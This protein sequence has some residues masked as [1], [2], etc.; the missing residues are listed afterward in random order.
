MKLASLT[1]DMGK[2]LGGTKSSDG[3]YIDHGDGTITDTRTNLMWAKKDS[4]SDTGSCMN[5]NDSRSYVSSLSTG[6]YSGWWMP[7]VQELKGIYDSSKRLMAFDNDSSTPLHLDSIFADGAAYWYW[8][9]ETV[10]S[11][12]ARIVSFG[13][14][15]VF[16]D[17]RDSCGNRGVRAVRR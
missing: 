17:G 15:N 10:G 9:S 12:R 7:T 13:S 4:Y 2:A 8:S 6:G 5:W 3:R 16:D 1:Q 14:A 11:S